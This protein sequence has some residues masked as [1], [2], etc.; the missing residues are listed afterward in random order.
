MPGVK[1]PELRENIIN[2]L[3]FFS[4][5]TKPSEWPDFT[6][7]VHWFVDDTFWDQHSPDEDVG[8]VL[9]NQGEAN[10]INAVLIPLLVILNELGPIGIDGDYYSHPLWIDVRNASTKAV[11]LLH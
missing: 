7:A 1:Y 5:E 10:A 4:A 6:N 8:I 3:Q 11:D 2:A 9:R